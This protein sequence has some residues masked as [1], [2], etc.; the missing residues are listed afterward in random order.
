M[1]HFRWGRTV[2]LRG[3]CTSVVRYGLR[4]ALACGCACIVAANVAADECV[5][6]R[7]DTTVATFS[8]RLFGGSIRIPVDYTLYG[9]SALLRR[10]DR[11]PVLEFHDLS[12]KSALASISIGNVADAGENL[13]KD[14]VLCTLGTLTVRQAVLPRT[15]ATIVH[16]NQHYVTLLNSDANAWKI[17]LQDF[18]E[19]ERGH[20]L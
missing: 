19:K 15:V 1:M 13:T 8:V 4:A 12:H 14:Q 18:A 17:L 20:I 16:D 3:K 2:H 11:P 9:D 6:D 10:G 5:I 7:R